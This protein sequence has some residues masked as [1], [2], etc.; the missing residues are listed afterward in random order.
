MACTPHFN[1]K[2]D[3]GWWADDYGKRIC[4]WTYDAN[5]MEIAVACGPTGKKRQL[6]T[7]LA[8]VEL[9]NQLAKIAIELEEKITGKRYDV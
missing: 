4:T 7:K 8:G 6:P 5:S 3:G 2:D 9:K 1:T